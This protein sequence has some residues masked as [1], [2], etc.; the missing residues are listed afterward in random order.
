MTN[1]VWF[2]DVANLPSSLANAKVKQL[3]DWIGKDNPFGDG[4]R[5]III[6]SN[7][8]KFSLIKTKDDLKEDHGDNVDEFINK[9]KYKLEDCLTIN[10]S[11]K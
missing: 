7:E 2:I 6:P 10:L 9:I 4:Y 5:V 8:N 1:I 3:S 11:Y